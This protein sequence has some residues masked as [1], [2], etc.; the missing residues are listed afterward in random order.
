MN[1]SDVKTLR[2]EAQSALDKVAKKYGV[3]LPIGTIRY[4]SDSIR[5][6]VKG[7]AGLTNGKTV[8]PLV[9]AY[10][11]FENQVGKKLGDTVY[12]G[13][14]KMKIVGAKPQNRKYPI[15]VE[16]ARGGRYKVSI[17]QIKLG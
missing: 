2:I 17:S 15:I 10:S 14:S 11:Q 16:G 13:G 12:I 8:D 6:S 7:A 1:R 4:G 9:A 3:T 5:F